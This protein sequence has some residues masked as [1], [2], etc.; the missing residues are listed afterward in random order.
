[1]AFDGYSMNKQRQSHMGGGEHSAGHPPHGSGDVA[2]KSGQHR[3]PHIHVH[4]HSR[5]HTVH[6][7]HDDGRHEQH[8]HAPGDAEGIAQ[9]IH[10][11]IGNGG[12]PVGENGMPPMEEEEFG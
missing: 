2:D 11:N 5:G 1:M 6:I 10:Q 3:P 12:Q 7:M 8:E 4:S 9:H